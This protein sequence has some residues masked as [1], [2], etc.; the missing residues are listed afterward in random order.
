MAMVEVPGGLAVG[1]R[2]NHG[3]RTTPRKL[4]GRLE[5]SERMVS[6][7]PRMARIQICKV[8]YPPPE[9]RIVRSLCHLLFSVR[10]AAICDCDYDCDCL[11]RTYLPS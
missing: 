4:E 2:S 10:V 1:S 5:K 9:I 6:R 7:S 11:V 3:R 8:F